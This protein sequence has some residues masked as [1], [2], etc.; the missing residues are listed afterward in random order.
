[1]KKSVKLFLFVPFLLVIFFAVTQISYN[2]TNS[3]NTNSERS[4]P[5]SIQV[6]TNPEC[7]NGSCTARRRS[8]GVIFGLSSTGTS[9][10]GSMVGLGPGIYDIKVCCGNKNGTGVVTLT[11]PF[12]NQIITINLANGTCLHD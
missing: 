5:Y 6:F 3:Y 8:D 7:Y 9:Y 4:V 2:N 12:D 11:P 1:M 10:Y